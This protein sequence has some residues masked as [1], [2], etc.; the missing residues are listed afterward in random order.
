MVAV[1]AHA[2]ALDG[3]P[4]KSQPTEKRKGEEE[5]LPTEGGRRSL[6]SLQR[7]FNSGEGPRVVGKVPLIR[8]LPL[9]L[10]LS[11]SFSLA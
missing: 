5:D 3:S 4:P 7:R 1:A 2:A 9:P 11:R 6:G 10:F 8:D